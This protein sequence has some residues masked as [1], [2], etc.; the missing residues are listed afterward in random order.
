M[1]L[2]SRLPSPAA[3]GLHLPAPWPGLSAAMGPLDP[4]KL[5]PPAAPADPVLLFIAAAWLAAEAL[6]ALLIVALAV[7]LTLPGGGP[8]RPLCRHRRPCCPRAPA[9]EVAG[10][11]AAAGP[12][13][14]C[15]T[16]STASACPYLATDRL[17][18]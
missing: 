4:M 10:G 13:P 14:S 17:I 5:N 7:A 16:I 6:A 9:G 8:H 12:R 15:G 1:E 11:G 2:T 18:Y 3:A